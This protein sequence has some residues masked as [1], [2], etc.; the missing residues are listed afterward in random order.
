MPKQPATPVPLV[1]LRVPPSVHAE[2]YCAS[3]L[4]SLS[5]FFYVWLCVHVHVSVCVCVSL[6]CLY[7]PPYP[8]L[9]PPNL[10]NPLGLKK[11]N[12]SVVSGPT[13]PASV[14]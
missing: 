1:L 3:K 9:L 8:P 13:L 6:C 7:S 10:R 5:P 14:R 11:G 4:I 12:P 2:I